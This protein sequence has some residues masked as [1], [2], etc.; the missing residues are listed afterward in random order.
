MELLLNLAWLLVATGAIVLLLHQK[1]DGVSTGRTGLLLQS[2]GHPR[3]TFIM[4]H[5][6]IASILRFVALAA[7]P[8]VFTWLQ[9]Q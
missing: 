9:T 6:M 4:R 7:G 1:H 8:H 2:S 5:S 3:G